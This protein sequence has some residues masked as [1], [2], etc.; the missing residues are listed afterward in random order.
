MAGNQLLLVAGLAR[1]RDLI[2]SKIMA[3]GRGI[4]IYLS[5]LKRGLI[6]IM[7]CCLTNMPASQQILTET[8]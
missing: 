5:I 4:D 7:V 8:D 1:G 6:G 2:R 3:L